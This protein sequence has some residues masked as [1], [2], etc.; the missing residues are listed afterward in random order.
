[1]QSAQQ[2][3]GAEPLGSAP[4]PSVRGAGLTG[5]AVEVCVSSWRAISIP[6]KGS[7][8]PV[9]SLQILLVGMV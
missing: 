8:L 4:D 3:E 7:L 2:K 1:M 6:K 9:R 5:A